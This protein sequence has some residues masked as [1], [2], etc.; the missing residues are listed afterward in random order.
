MV[1]WNK[2]NENKLIKLWESKTDI[3]LSEIFNTTEE[4]IKAKRH[5]LGLKR[6]EKILRNTKEY[7]YAEVLNIFESRGYILISKKYINYTTALEYI[8]MLHPDKG[9]QSINLCDL[10]RGRGCYYCGRERTINSKKHT[11][12]ELILE[13]QKRNFKYVGNYVKN[14]VTYV[15]Y[16]CNNHPYIGV[17]EKAINSFFKSYNCPHCKA[18]KGETKLASILNNHSID[19]ITQYK[20][21]DCRDKYPLP[22]DFYLTNYNICIEYDGELHYSPLYLKQWTREEAVQKLIETQ[23]RDDIKN[24]YCKEKNIPLIRIPYWELNNMEYFLFDQL[25][26]YNIAI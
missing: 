26:K 5:R 19:F 23:N 12:K 22:F 9:I 15:Q 17:Q 6:K 4:A 10:L 14:N 2:D 7:T 8:C 13:C 11:E 18:S 1:R 3:E 24:K 25:K 16:I 21:D 20:F